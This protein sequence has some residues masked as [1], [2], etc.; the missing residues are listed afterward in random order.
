MKQIIISFFAVLLVLSCVPQKADN[1]INYE[2]SSD[3]YK[4][5]E[6][7]DKL[8][9]VFMEGYDQSM[10]PGDPILPFKVI[11]LAVPPNTDMKSIKLKMDARYR[12]L[13]EKVDILPGPALKTRVKDEE[14]THWKNK[15]IIDGRNIKIYNVDQFYPAELVRILT[16]GQM[17]KWKFVR[18]AYF[19]IQYNPVQ[20]SIRQAVNV[21][22][23]LSYDTV[24][25]KIEEALLKDNVLDS[26]AKLR[27]AN[28]N[29]AA[30]WYAPWDDSD[31][32]PSAMYTY[33]I[34]TT[35]EIE[36]NLGMT[37]TDF[38]NH[39]INMGFKVLTITDDEYGTETGQ[40]P[41]KIRAWL[42]N[43]Y[44]DMNIKY[45]LLIGDPD[46]YDQ[47]NETDVIGDIPMKQCWPNRKNWIH[48]EYPTDYFYADL[49]GDWDLDGDGYF[50]EIDFSDNATS[51][52]N[53]IDP[54]TFS[55]KWTGKI[56]ADSDGTYDF[57]CSSNEGIRIIINGTTVIDNWTH[58]Y[59]AR[60]VGSIYLLTGLHDIEIEYFNINT[61]AF[62]TLF[63]SSPASA[64]VNLV[65]DEDLYYL[66]NDEY[67]QGGLKGEY[68]NNE[69]FTN[70][71]F[72][73]IDPNIYFFWVSGDQGIA[74][75][76][77]TPEVFVGRIPVY[78][79]DYASTISILEK[80]IAYETE[81]PNPSWRKEVLL[82]M[83]PSDAQ[84]PGYNLGEGIKDDAAIPLGYT[85]YRIYEEDYGLVPA[86]ELTP[87]NPTNVQNNWDDGYGL[88]TWWTHGGPNNASWIFHISQ[89]ASLDNTKPSF[90]YQCS[91]Y[92]GHPETHDNLG[93][94]LLRHG[95]ISTISASRVSW[96]APGNY[97]FSPTSGLNP[98]L[99]Y[100]YSINLMEG[101]RNGDAL[102]LS[103][104]QSTFWMNNMVFNIYGDPAIDLIGLPDLTVVE[105]DWS[106]SGQQYVI[107]LKI[108]NIGGTD[109]GQCLVYINAIDPTPPAG[110]NEI[111]IQLTEDLPALA[112][113]EEYSFT[114]SIDL[115]DIHAKEVKHIEV[116]VDP[117]DDVKESDETNN[118]E[119]W[120]WDEGL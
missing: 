62:I 54:T 3:K 99:A 57:I 21:E 49:T 61:D 13:E 94:E 85:Y 104:S 7:K 6:T 36:S 56:E 48:R 19:P 16:T 74:G 117:K 59:A 89:C 26:E 108:K 1:V 52:D 90:T 64:N 39:K 60:D 65:S 78:D 106:I 95:A 63:W 107:N 15:P 119:F 47:D 25:E 113:G 11:E 83:K 2:F 118:R 28:I 8:A 114:E 12:D 34:V 97:P 105:K 103:T 53:S 80:T 82:P 37:L 110:I 45:V 91:C 98:D 33:V 70:L 86:P 102:Y 71:V 75:V 22:I 68:F 24:K 81:T 9:Q 87:C 115:S 14:F 43:N 69:D 76:D 5:R 84:T 111:R 79:A 109:S 72:D 67:V 40:A 112:P 35:N 23:S 42:I 93:F 66:E 44:L 17:R 30:A 10:S 31:L 73:R 4:I 120:I 20:N 55:I 58:H 51:P 96:Y 46:P 41:E 27:F 32:Q 18:I 77:F 88:V 38:V 101:L 116:L 50:G 92:N 100:Y 29:E